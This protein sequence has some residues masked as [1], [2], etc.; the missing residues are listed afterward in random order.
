M[1]NVTR[2]LVNSTVSHI[3]ENDEGYIVHAHT[4]GIFQLS[5]C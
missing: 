1:Y 3:K 5:N 4:T 2:G